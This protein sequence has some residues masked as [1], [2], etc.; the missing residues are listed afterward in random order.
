MS[1]PLHLRNAPTQQTRDLTSQVVHVRAASVN[2][3]A[4]TVDAVLA[5]EVV[6]QVYDWRRDEVIDEVLSIG[7]VEHPEQAPFLAVHN[8]WDIGAVLGA[9]RSIRTEGSNLIGTLHFDDDED[10]QRA[11]RKVTRG[12]ITD[13]SVGYRTVEWIDIQPGESKK[14]NGRTYTAESR[15]LRVTTKWELRE[16]SLVPIGADPNAK[17]REQPGSV[18]HTERTHPMKLNRKTRRYLESIGVVRS[19]MSEAEAYAA[20]QNLEGSQREHADAVQADPAAYKD[21]GVNR[22]APPANNPDPAEP[23]DTADDNGGEGQRSEPG[24]G[25]RNGQG[26]GN[27]PD[28]AA[29]RQRAAEA[30]RDRIRGI[31][32]LASDITPAAVVTRAINEGLTVE[33]AS[34]AILE[35]E[36]GLRGGSGDGQGQAPAVHTRTLGRTAA[37]AA[38]SAGLILRCGMGPEQIQVANSLNPDQRTAEQARAA[39]QGERFSHMS[40]IDLCRECLRHEGLSVHGSYA[41]IFQRAVSTASLTQVFTDAVTASVG[42]GFATAPD[43]TL[44]WTDETD[45]AN[46][47]THTDITLGKSSGLKKLGRNGHAPDATIDDEAETYSVASYGEKFILGEDDAIDDNF[48]ALSEMPREMAEEAAQLRPDLVYG[49]LLANANMADGTALFHADHANLGTTSTALAAA[50][51]QAGIVAMAKQTRGNRQ[52]NIRPQYLLVP[53]DLRFT[54]MQL[55]SSAEIRESAAA[56]GTANVLAQENLRVISE[57]RLGVAGVTHPETGTAYA[58]TATNWFLAAARRTVRVAFLAGRNRRPQVRSFVLTQGQWGI[59]WDLKHIIGVYARDHRGLY[60]A[61]GAGA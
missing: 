29:E 20:Y 45:V 4:R 33:Q 59:G 39:E 54:A 19:D 38:M 56:N 16:V 51:L 57:N 2:E 35:S 13:V 11:F 7:G 30:E 61:T 23:S 53:Q 43:S 55:I 1:E 8:R 14:I 31:Q 18:A 27:T 34:L 21:D 50:T 44:G 10:A 24:G 36:R 46:F 42:M 22:A 12:F 32:E 25:N 52:L 9:L 6:A 15:V 48:S 26:G 58:G 37:V 41:E 17:I 49:T 47:R 28:L 40:V 60:K 3:E 5:T